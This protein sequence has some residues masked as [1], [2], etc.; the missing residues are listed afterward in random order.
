MKTKS[1]TAR[2][3]ISTEKP[4]KTLMLHDFYTDGEFGN[5]EVLY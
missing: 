4:S 3:F 1:R 2:S 5:L